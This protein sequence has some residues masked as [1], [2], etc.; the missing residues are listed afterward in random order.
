MRIKRTLIALFCVGM[1]VAH[2]TTLAQDELTGMF[3]LS[4]TTTDILG[5]PTAQSL[6]E[7]AALD[8]QLQWQVYV[9]DNYQRSRP[10]GVFVF[11]DPDGWGGIPDQFRQLFMARNMI[12]IGLKRNNR[13]PT[14]GKMKLQA[15]LAARV[16]E[17][18]YSVDLNRLYIGASGDS[19]VT[20]IDVL[21]TA[22]EFAGGIYIKGSF[23]WQ[24]QRLPTV[25]NLQRKYHVFIT[26]T[27]DKAKQTVRRDYQNY[28]KEGIENVKLIFDMDRIGDWPKPDQMDEALA[29]LDSRL[30]R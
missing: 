17:Q 4:R 27:N 29:Y 16:I 26:G 28:K 7:V 2:S 19:V 11:V 20:A 14:Q 23:Y 1:A 3:R 13:R 15:V 10:P 22:G 9:P 5:A 8:E 24:D 30:M 18:T 6:S 25:D 21:L 12:W